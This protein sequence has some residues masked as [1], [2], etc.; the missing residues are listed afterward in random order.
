M[1][2]ENGF[3]SIVLM[4]IITIFIGVLIN[5]YYNNKFIE[6]TKDC[7]DCSYSQRKCFKN[8][9]LENIN[10]NNEIIDVDDIVNRCKLLNN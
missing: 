8:N 9:R 5:N 3:I 1:K 7:F 10:S 6:D 2:K 4:V